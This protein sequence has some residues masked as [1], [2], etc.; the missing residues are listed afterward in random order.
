MVCLLFVT[1]AVEQLSIDKM[2]F[3]ATF[4]IVSAYFALCII[5]AP[6]IYY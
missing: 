4:E 1:I 2:H 5:D 3:G 6:H